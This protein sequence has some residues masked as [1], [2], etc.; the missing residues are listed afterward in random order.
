[1]KAEWF[2]YAWKETGYI[3]KQKTKL[4]ENPSAKYH[5]VLL[6]K[7]E[8]NLMSK[9]GDCKIVNKELINLK[10]KTMKKEKKEK[11]G[12]K[13][14]A[15]KENNVKPGKENKAD[16]SNDNPKEKK[17]G[18]PDSKIVRRLDGSLNLAKL[19]HVIMKKKNKK[20]KEIA[21]IV[22][23]LKDN[24]IEQHA[25]GGIFL[26]V[27]VN[28]KDCEDNFNQHGFIS[29]QVPTEIYKAASEKEREEMK[30]PILGGLK[31]WGFENTGGQA[32]NSPSK[33]MEEDDDLP[34]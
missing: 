34:F 12:K 33:E 7:E 3:W 19:K 21:C 22:I 5:L 31:D 29:Q 2:Y 17:A 23:P 25:G 10:T 20:G 11:E 24:Y 26:G 15:E 30:T 4:T 6:N 1:M 16:K 28:L 18:N 9:L 32:A 8:A 27:K 14:K 13:N